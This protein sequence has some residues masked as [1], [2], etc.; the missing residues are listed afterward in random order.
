MKKTLSVI[1]LILMLISAFAPLSASAEETSGSCGKNAEWQFKDNVLTVS[2]SGVVNE[3]PWKSLSLY[4]SI[5]KV[6]ISEGITEITCR[7]AFANCENLKEAYLPESLE[8]VPHHIF[9]ECEKLEKA[10]LPSNIKYISGGAFARCYSLKKI[11]IP[12]SVT[13]IW[14]AAFDNCTSATGTLFIPKDTLVRYY[15]F[16]NCD[17]I[18]EVV[19][20]EGYTIKFESDEEEYYVDEDYAFQSCDNL[21]KVTIPSSMK[22]IPPNYFTN[23]KSLTDVVISEGVQTVGGFTKCTSLKEITLPKSVK[24]ISDKAFAGCPNLEL[25]M[26]YEVKRIGRLALG[27]KLVKEGKYDIPYAI[28]GFKIYGKKF[29]VLTEYCK[30]NGFTFVDMYDV[31]NASV[32]GLGSKAYTGKAIKPD[33]TVKL[34]GT[35]LKKDTDYTVKYSNNTKVGTAKVTLTGKGTYK[36]TITKTFK[37]NP[38]PTELTK[39]TSGSKSFKAYWKKNATQT[40][41][42]QIQYSTYKDFKNAKTVSITSYKTGARTIKKLKAN[43]KYFVRIRAYKTIN[44]KKQYSSWSAKKTVTTKK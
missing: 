42:Y 1:L 34:A 27:Y 20:E 16:K 9:A 19:F 6:I 39:L 17:S 24:Y 32:S 14:P 26:P 13:S 35:T 8:Y 7:Y 37:I 40:S 43:K 41:G 23:C 2:G 28:E 31:K 4:N 3:C 15:A 21:K 12:K 11:I 10:D 36:G 29:N 33:V 22:I 38:K 30:N 25:K 5:K 44:G 18:S